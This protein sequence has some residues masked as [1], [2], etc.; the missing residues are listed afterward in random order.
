VSDGP[1]LRVATATA[2]FFFVMVGYYVLKPVRDSF[3]LGEL[4]YERLPAGDLVVLAVT[5]AAGQVYA[6]VAG[7]VER[8]RLVLVA[9]ACF[10]ACLLGFWLLLGPGGAGNELRRRMAWVYYCWVSVYAVF[11]VSLFWSLTHSVFGPG[12]GGAWY[13]VIGSG[14]TVGALVGGLVTSGL[15]ERLGTE[16]MLLLGL[17]ALLPAVLLG[18]A[19]ARM[20]PRGAAPDPGLPAKG[21]LETVVGDRY[22][23][24][25]ALLVTVAVFVA[26]LDDYRLKQIVQAAHPGLDAR[27]AFMGSVY[28]TTN[29]VGLALSLLVAGFLQTRF[30]PLPGL[31]SYPL[32]IVAVGLLMLRDPAIGTAFWSMV[33]LQSTAYSIFQS[34]REMLFLTEPV[35]TKFVA[36]G[37]IGTLFFRA[38]G[39][40]A[41]L[42]ALALG[43]APGNLPTSILTVGLALGLLAAG[44][45]LD[46]EYRR[47]A[48]GVP[49]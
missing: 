8:G 27:T 47:R 45:G 12:E 16:N 42:L 30:G 7:R 37:L 22:L 41:A 6:G 19:L 21:A 9:N 43:G 18:M 32:C 15:S 29:A 2:Y 48:L 26:H 10:A 14:G 3:F 13:G 4:G 49:A 20:P 1:F 28:S 36:K 39:G 34:S 46:R 11:A 23:L 25:H 44:F 24:A 17:V 33:A 5:A 40:L 31:A 38:G 35:A